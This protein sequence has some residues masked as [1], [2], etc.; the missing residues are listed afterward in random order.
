MV[1]IYVDER[2]KSSDVPLNLSSMGVSLVF[3]VLDVGDYAIDDVFI[4]RKRIDDL[5]RS[6]YEGRFFDQ[7]KRLKSLEKGKPVLIVEGDVF[8]LGRYVENPRPIEAALISA[9]LSFNIPVLYTRDSKHTAELLRYVAERIQRARKESASKKKAMLLPTYRKSKK[10][11][12]EDVRSWQVYI[13]S[14]FPKVGPTLAERLLHKFGSLKA[15]INAH[16]TE[17]LRVEGMT[18]DRVKLFKRVVDEGS[19]GPSST[20]LERFLRKGDKPDQ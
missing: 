12:T 1:K 7:L 19:S 13:L 15:V 10:P 20:T 18:E 14:S 17:L 6:V 16:A 4:E 9:V 3:K 5:V 8:N 2:E 11:K